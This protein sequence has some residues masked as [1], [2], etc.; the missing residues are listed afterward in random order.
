MAWKLCV[1]V[2]SLVLLDFSLLAAARDQRHNH[3]RA[4]ASAKCFVPITSC[5]FAGNHSSSDSFVDAYCC[6]SNDNHIVR[7]N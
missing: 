4:T 1:S 5:A 6:M 7:L 2:F 3:R